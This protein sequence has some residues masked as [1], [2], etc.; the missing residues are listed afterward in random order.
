MTEPTGPQASQEGDAGIQ[1]AVTLPSATS[2]YLEVRFV[3]TT[4]AGTII[5]TVPFNNKSI[6]GAG[7]TVPSD[8][9][10]IKV[11]V[12][13]TA[14]PPDFIF[15]GETASPVTVVT[16]EQT[17][18]NIDL[19]SVHSGRV[20]I[21]NRIMY[22]VYGEVYNGETSQ[23]A[24]DGTTV[25]LNYNGTTL[26]ETTLVNGTFNLLAESSYVGKN[27]EVQAI[28][29]QYTTNTNIVVNTANN[30]VLIVF[31]TLEPVPMNPHVI[32]SIIPSS[33]LYQFLDVDGDYV[34]TGHTDQSYPHIFSH[35]NV[36]DPIAPSVVW[37]TNVDRVVGTSVFLR[38]GT[39]GVKTAGNYVYTTLATLS[40][41]SLMII[42]KTDPNNGIVASVLD[43]S[44]SGYSHDVD[45]SGNY[46]YIACNSGLIIADIS[47]P[48]NPFIVAR[49]QSANAAD[50]V[51]VNDIAYLV[52]NDIGLIAL[53][54]SDPTAPTHLWTVNISYYPHAVCINGNYAY[55]SK[56][57][58]DD[59]LAIV[60]ISTS[61]PSIVNTI[62]T[63][64]YT[65][66]ACIQGNYLYVGT[67]A[68]GLKIFDIHDP[69]HPSLLFTV[70]IN[71]TVYQVVVQ[72]N[73]AYVANG[74]DGIS[75]VELWSE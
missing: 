57:L 40:D 54:V 31:N 69:V 71:N 74:I 1:F 29:G 63:G 20:I 16:A 2:G 49:Y 58:S 50:V 46:A 65:R 13:N 6:V 56:Y 44:N 67:E 73:K 8:T 28:S 41:P 60:D 27:V 59:N 21:R 17:I 3:S 25:K 42:D 37:S 36:S 4:G 24:P 75:I 19:I 53:D 22:V 9:Y 62:D 32:G 43:V 48:A 70:P 64:K 66:S 34:Y 18:V 61:S 38:Y 45:I 7:F 30:Y 68:N 5:K 11:K 33:G 35:I 47:T 15:Y 55:V 51:V 26:D 23:L 52:N 39:E 12:F 72:G 10:D 14:T